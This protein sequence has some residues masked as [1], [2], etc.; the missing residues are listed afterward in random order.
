[1]IAAKLLAV[2]AGKYKR[3]HGLA[4]DTGGGHHRGVGALPQSLG[5]LLGHGVDRAQR[6]GECR[7]GLQGAPHDE[8]LPIRHAALHASGA[9]GLA[10]PA[11]LLR[12]E[13]L[14]VG[15]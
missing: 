1:V 9:I 7:D 2:A 15:L 3:H 6:L 4:D 11:K 12:I 14:V 13:D 10:V 5:G 8:R